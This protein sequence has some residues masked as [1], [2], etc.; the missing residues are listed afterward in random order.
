MSSDARIV[1]FEDSRRRILDAFDNHIPTAVYGG[2]RLEDLIRSTLTACR[3]AVVVFDLRDL[4]SVRDFCGRIMAGIGAHIRERPRSARLSRPSL[5]Q[6]EGELGAT[7]NLLN[8]FDDDHEFVSSGA[9]AQMIC[10]FLG[11]LEDIGRR[12]RIA[13]CFAEFQEIRDALDV[14]DSR[15]VLGLLRGRIQWHENVVYYFSGSKSESFVRLFTSYEQ[16][17][18]EGAQLHRVSHGD[19]ISS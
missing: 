15:H 14:E 4:K 18:F 11:Q 9:C 7:K 3:H 5:G 2:E 6:I 16:P 19:I 1:D 13:A 12:N 17:F 10:R 8:R